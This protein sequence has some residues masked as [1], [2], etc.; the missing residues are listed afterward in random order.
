MVIDVDLSILAEMV[1][2]PVDLSVRMKERRLMISSGE[3]RSL[4]GQEKGGGE[5]GWSE[6]GGEG[7]LKQAEK[8]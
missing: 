6:R 1:S 7:V 5:G 2:G 4:G 3:Q 8:K